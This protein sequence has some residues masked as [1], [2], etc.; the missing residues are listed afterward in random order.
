MSPVTTEL[1][2]MVTCLPM[3]R[4]GQH[5]GAEPEPRTVA[6]RDRALG[7]RLL[8]DRPGDV[9]VAVVLIGDVDV[10]AGPHVVAD[11][12]AEVADD[13]TA[14]ADQASIAD[15]HDRI[16]EARLARHH[17]GR[18][19]DLRAD[20]RALADVDVPLVE[21]GVVR[22]ADDA[23]RTE[24][25]ELLARLRRRARSSRPGRPSPTPRRTHSPPMRYPAARS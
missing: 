9:L 25:A 13:A 10:V 22:E 3:C 23:A 12:D 15:A 5:H 21:D 4:A 14:L 19:R 17:A 20:H 11:V 8:R 24:A 1:A 7:L 18:E 16:G 6:D 2:P